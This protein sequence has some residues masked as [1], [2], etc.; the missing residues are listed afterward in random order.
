MVEFAF[1]APPLLLLMFGLIEFSRYTYAQSALDY[2]A[3]EATRFA[4]VNGGSV[5]NDQIIAIAQDNMLF[6]DTGLSAVCV[7]SPTDTATSTST[8]SVTIS[9]DYDPIIPLVLGNQTMQ[10][11]SQGFIAFTPVDEPNDSSGSC[12]A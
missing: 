12:G 8:V 11:R 6:L 9:Y 3:E 4:I 1:V 2:A 10:G 7:L 5:T